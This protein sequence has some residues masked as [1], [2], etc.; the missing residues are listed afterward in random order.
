MAVSTSAPDDQLIDLID[1]AA[2]REYYGYRDRDMPAMLDLDSGLPPEF[3]WLVVI[4]VPLGTFLASFMTEAGKDAYLGLKDLVGQLHAK[5]RR[6]HGTG[7]SIVQ[8]R[9]PGLEMSLDLDADLP[10]QAYRDLWAMELPRLPEDYDLDRLNWRDEYGWILL[11]RVP[12]RVGRRVVG[13]APIGLL[14]LPTS[15]W[16]VLF[17]PDHD[18]PSTDRFLEEWE[19][20]DRQAFE[21]MRESLWPG[22]KERRAEVQR[23]EDAVNAEMQAEHEQFMR[24]LEANRRRLP[25]PAEN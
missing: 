1:E 4:T 21:A 17:L 13:D 7:E 10:D 14:W 6:S 3:P 24:E 25:P 22:T 16:Q 18:R 20:S 15:K 5:V 8:L 11:I 23:R 19:P 9:D 2:D 12:V